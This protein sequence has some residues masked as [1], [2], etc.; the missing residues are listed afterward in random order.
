MTFYLPSKIDGCSLKRIGELPFEIS[1]DSKCIGIPTSSESS[2]KILLVDNTWDDNGS[3][4][5]HAVMYV[6]NCML[7]TVC[8]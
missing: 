5:K 4:V 8:F 3:D 7:H 6:T 2:D 1:P